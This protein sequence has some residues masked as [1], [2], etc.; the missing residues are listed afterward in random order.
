MNWKSA[1]MK[2]AEKGILHDVRCL[3]GGGTLDEPTCRGRGWATCGEMSVRP[4]VAQD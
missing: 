2:N 3:A 1:K 4:F